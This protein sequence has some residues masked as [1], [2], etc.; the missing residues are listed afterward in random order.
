MIMVSL[1]KI[2]TSQLSLSFGASDFAGYAVRST[3]AL[4][5]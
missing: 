5:V 3:G 4:D 1:T 2:G